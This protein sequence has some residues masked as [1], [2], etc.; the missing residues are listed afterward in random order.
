VQR[1]DSVLGDEVDRLRTQLNGQEEGLKA[2]KPGHERTS[3]VCA[4][5]LLPTDI[6]TL[7]TR[8]A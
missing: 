3:P 6:A 8:L 4:K 1:E 2:Y 7:R 5:N